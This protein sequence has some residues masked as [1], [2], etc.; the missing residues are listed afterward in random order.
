MFAGGKG[1]VLK[2]TNLNTGASLTIRT[3]GSVE[4]TRLNDDGT[5]TTT[6]LGHSVV[7]LFPTDIPAGP[8]TKLY[9]GRLV[10]NVDAEYT[11]T[12]LSSAGREVDI[13]A[14]LN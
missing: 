5:S 9:L 4:Q 14:A 6:V 13:C 7:T 10:F 3:G 1:N 11:F 12:Q 8:S 2:F